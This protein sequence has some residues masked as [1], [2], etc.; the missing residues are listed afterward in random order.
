MWIKVS[1]KHLVNLAHYRGVRVETTKDRSTA[2]KA[3][4]F[5]VCCYVEHSN[6]GVVLAY[7]ETEEEAKAVLK[8][9][10]DFLH[11]LPETK[12]VLLDLG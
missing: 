10:R 5:P 2:G 4:G 6:S 12:A 3:S 1:D 7:K 8:Q 11:S 9:I